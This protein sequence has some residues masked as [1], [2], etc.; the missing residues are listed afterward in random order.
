MKMAPRWS[1][2]LLSPRAA[3]FPPPLDIYL[4]R[5]DGIFFFI[6]A[7]DSMR[8]PWDLPFQLLLSRWSRV[9]T[10]FFLNGY[11]LL[12]GRSFPQRTPLVTTFLS[13]VTSNGLEFSSR[14]RHGQELAQ[15]ILGSCSLELLLSPLLKLPCSAITR[16]PRVI[17]A[18]FP[19]SWRVQFHL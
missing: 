6:S 15:G 12:Y 5:S 7:P 4:T 18:S 3:I 16:F 8:G 11:I 2:E 9:Q 13:A 10:S 19:S 14:F 1:G 17:K